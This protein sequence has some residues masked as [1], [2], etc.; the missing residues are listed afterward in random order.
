MT[1]TE[2]RKEER[3]MM[4]Y[5][6]MTENGQTLYITSTSNITFLEQEKLVH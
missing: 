2:R 4:R 1:A 3:C 5:S 6:G